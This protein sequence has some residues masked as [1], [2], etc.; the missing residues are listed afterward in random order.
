MRST[1]LCVAMATALNVFKVRSGHTGYINKII[2]EA[3][4]LIKDCSDNKRLSLLKYAIEEQFQK[5][6][7]VTA[8]CLEQTSDKSLKEIKLYESIFVDKISK[9]LSEISKNL[10]PE[11]APPPS[12]EELAAFE[13]TLKV[14]SEHEGETAQYTTDISHDKYCTTNKEKARSIKAKSIKSKSGKSSSFSISSLAQ[15]REECKL[16]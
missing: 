14:Q 10:G 15:V 13:E 4:Q 11:L 3:E 9:V 5:Y 12:P 6:K 16:K 8:L 1:K 2:K 7:R